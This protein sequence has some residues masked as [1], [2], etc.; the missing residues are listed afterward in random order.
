MSKLDTNI[1]MTSNEYRH[2]L[3]NGEPAIF[4]RWAEV[5]QIVIKDN[6]VLY[7]AHD[8]SSEINAIHGMFIIPEYM[9]CEKAKTIFGIVELKDGSVKKVEIEN[10]KFTDTYIM[11][12]KNK[13]SQANRT[14]GITYGKII[15]VEF[16]DPLI[17]KE[18]DKID[19]KFHDNGYERV[20]PNVATFSYEKYIVEN[21]YIHRID[22]FVNNDGTYHIHSY[23]KS[24][25][26]AVFTYS[27]RL[28]DWQIELIKFKVAQY[29]KSI[30]DTK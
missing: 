26:N 7:Q 1:T 29:Y 6:R 25:K 13:Y 9:S 3:V 4:H 17:E 23:Q 10:I 21:N 16:G 8:Y 18:W 2:C 19:Y 22:I 5:E 14:G 11:K 20:Y 24:K 15:A 12:K 27:V 28:C 30:S